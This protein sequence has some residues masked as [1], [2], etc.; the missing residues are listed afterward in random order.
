MAHSWHFFRAGGVDQVAIR[1]GADILALPELD[2]KL[3]VAL[4]MPTR[5]VAVDPATMD[6]LDGDNDGR[7]RV[8]DILEAVAWIGATWKNADDLTKSADAVKLSAIKDAA[9]A[10]AAK[11]ILADAGKPDADSISLGLVLD[12]VK[13]F[14]D[15][16]LNGDGIVI[17][18]TAGDDADTK[19]AIEEAIAA[20][21]AETDRSGKPGIDQAKTDAFFADVDKAAE[22]HAGGGAVAALGADTA[23]AADALAAVKAKIE[24]YFA[25]AALAAFDPRAIPGLNGQEADFTALGAHA[26]TAGADDIAK[27]PLATVAAGKA[28]PL[29]AGVNPAWAGKLAT[30]AEVAVK[31]IVGAKDSL[32]PEDF[33]AVVAK[34]A[35]FDAWRGGKPDTGAAKLDA[36]RVKA[37]ATGDARKKIAKLIED[38]KALAGDYDA[39][40]GVEKL[41][42][43]Q[44]DFAKILRNFVNFTEFYS[45]K[46]GVFQAGTLYLDGR[47]FSLTFP[48]SDAGRHGTLAPMSGA[49]LAYCDLKR[50]GATRSIA[51]ALT[52]GDADNVFVGRNGIFYDRDGKDWDATITKVVSNPISVRE[53]FFAPY[54]K[55]VRGIEGAINKRAADAEAK[56]AAKIDG[57]AAAVATADQA[58]PADAAAAAPKKGLDIGIIAVI[59]L[60]IGAVMGAIGG[61]VALLIGMGKWAPLGVAA[62]LMVISG[63]SM[64]LAWMKL[65]QRNLGPILD[66]NGWAVNTKARVNVAFGASMTSLAKLPAG[67]SQSVDDPY[68]DKKSPWKLW[69]ALIIVVVAAASWYAGKLDKWLPRSAQS[70]KVIGKSAPGYK[71]SWREEEDLKKEEAKKAAEQAVKDAADKAAADKA[72]ADKAAADKAAADKAAADKAAAP[73]PAPEAPAAPADPAAAPQ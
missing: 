22:W 32:T 20:V 73:P 40:A 3:W 70:V 29:K 56:S 60:A 58:K 50:A 55:L 15:T 46:D 62:L 23:A 13:A 38:D 53:A 54:K 7:V 36:D 4:A 34:L 63:P 72:A 26:L 28:L 18:A 24:D 10:G 64:L 49:F 12:A 16:K 47:A 61:L 1:S 65:R 5:D 27:L 52:N 14:A 68:A 25:R 66:A 57:A 59:S 71:G 8:P 69:L 67:S 6:L 35:A 30:F 9:V 31:P 19:Q 2:Q 39:I 17:P 51:A 45:K 41:C 42:R 43:L 21:G 37:L 33:A 11:R 44:R 48:V